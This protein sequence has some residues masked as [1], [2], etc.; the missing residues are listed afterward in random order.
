MKTLRKSDLVCLRNG[1]VVDLIHSR[2]QKADI[3]IRGEK[4]DSIGTINESEFRGE[5]IDISNCIIVAGLVDMHVHLREPGREDEETVE[6]GCA[7]AMAGG[8]T[9]VAAMPNTDPPCDN[10][11]IVNFLFDRARSQLV[12]VYPVA[13]ITKERA[14]KEITEMG[15]LAKAGVVAFSDD[16][17]SVADSGVM[18]RALEYASMYETVIIDHSEELALAAGGH[19]NEGVMST[20]LGVAGIPTT[21]EDVMVA[22]NI[23]LLRFSGGFLHIAHISSDKS[24]EMVR[25]A[26]DEHLSISCEV[27]PHHLMFSDEDLIQ[28]DTNLKMNPPLRPPAI[29]ERLKAG[30]ADGTIDVIA[31]DH[32]PHSIEEK[33]V[34]FDAAPFGITGLETMVGVIITEIVNSGILSLEE[35][36]YKMSIAPRKLLRLDVPE[37]KEGKRAN[38]SVIE[39]SKTWTVDAGRQKSLSR[40]TPYDGMELTG[41]IRAVI[42]R[43]KLWQAL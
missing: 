22:R 27:T 6:S 21:A 2:R 32:A 18:R 30:L 12:D 15:E 24:V 33:D 28:Y 36:L 11:E 20:R 23:G 25:R 35:A 43:G 29:I 8:F 14:G 10:Q 19:M 41:G 38:L 3:V 7:A 17:A 16:G 4:I 42:N 34:E 40:N 26:K 31:S 1:E 13:A 37:I 9:G 39:P 5:I